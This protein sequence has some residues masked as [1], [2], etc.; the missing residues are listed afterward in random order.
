MG[1]ASGLAD[2]VDAPKQ[3]VDSS[4]WQ[5]SSEVEDILEKAAAEVSRLQAA[6]DGVVN[7]LEVLLV[8]DDLQLQGSGV[9]SAAAD[10]LAR[11]HF[12]LQQQSGKASGL[13]KQ[14]DDLERRQSL[15]EV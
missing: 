9:S 7:A 11:V 1:A 10:G 14:V 5:W 15:M 2:A 8:S 4:S 3:P 13:M 12:R 6:E